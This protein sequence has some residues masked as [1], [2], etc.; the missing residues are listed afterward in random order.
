VISGVAGRRLETV[1]DL[2]TV[3]ERQRQ[4]WRLEIERGEQ[5]LSAV[6]G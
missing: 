6:I 3:L 2:V 4:P 5:R 1:D